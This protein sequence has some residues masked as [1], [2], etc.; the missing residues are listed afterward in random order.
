[1]LKSAHF[2]A[3][4][5]ASGVFTFC[6]RIGASPQH[7]MDY[8]RTSIHKMRFSQ[9]IFRSARSRFVLESAQ[10]GTKREQKKRAVSIA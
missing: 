8:V 9:T 7:N 2:A 3:A 5:H 1:M 10:P 6:S 4:Q